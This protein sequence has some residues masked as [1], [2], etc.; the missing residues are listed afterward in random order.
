MLQANGRWRA[1]PWFALNQWFLGKCPTT[2]DHLFNEN[3][4]KHSILGIQYGQCLKPN[5]DYTV[6]VLEGGHMSV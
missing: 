4:P 5:L 1:T 2:I 3:T 6:P